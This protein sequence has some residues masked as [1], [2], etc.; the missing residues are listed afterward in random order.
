MTKINLQILRTSV[1]IFVLLL[2]SNLLFSQN[3]DTNTNIHIYGTSYHPYFQLPKG[4][5][6]D[7][8]P[9][10][11]EFIATYSGRSTYKGD[12][13]FSPFSCEYSITI[14]IK[15]D[16]K[17][18][19]DWKFNKIKKDSNDSED[20]VHT[21][22]I[23]DVYLNWNTIW[24]DMY[25]LDE[26]G[27]KIVIKPF[28]AFFVTKKEPNGEISGLL[29]PDRYEGPVFLPIVNSGKKTK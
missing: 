2:A 4:Y 25:Y 1:I 9:G 22:F 15:K 27:N 3:L 8:S 11:E 14:H 17:I 20:P 29:L 21:L 13:R 26:K 5:Y 6:W 24:G 10:E 28:L 18:S 16:K 23:K 7:S 12:R 19:I